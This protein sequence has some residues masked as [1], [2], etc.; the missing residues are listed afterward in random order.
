MEFDDTVTFELYLKN[1]H[2][3][4][5]RDLLCDAFT[6]REEPMVS[7]IPYESGAFQF[8]CDYYLEQ[9]ETYKMSTVCVEK[10]SGRVVGVLVT[11]DLCFTEDP[12]FLGALEDNW[13]DWFPQIFMAVEQLE[14]PLLRELAESDKMEWGKV[15]HM[16]ML[17]VAVDWCHRG[18][19][20][21]IVQENLQLAQERDYELVIADCTNKYSASIF[22]KLGFRL[23][24]RLV[25]A[26]YEF[27]P[28]SGKFPMREKLRERE[29]FD[30]MVL[31]TRP[32]LLQKRKISTGKVEIRSRL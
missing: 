20:A 13:G 26:D 32:V 7:H 12:A 15:W 14:K 19:G 31:M 23:H 30:S 24:T 29:G 3:S 5:C 8:F 28:S 10:K 25:Y 27:P 21:R 9:A 6:R 4:Q 1:K 2:Q 11:N 18:L 22:E 17:A 16:W